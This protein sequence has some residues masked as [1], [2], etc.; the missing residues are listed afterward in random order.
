[1]NITQIGIDLA[2]AVFQVHGVDAR[3]KAVLRKQLR[4]AQLASFF[5]RL[6]PCLVG[7]E[8]CGG[9]HFWARKLTGLGH[10]V[11]NSHC[12]AG[13]VKPYVKTNKNDV[14]D[15]EAICE[16]VG[17]PNMRFVP[18]KNTDQQTLLALHRA[19]AGF[20]H[21]AYGASQSGPR[22]IGGV[23]PD[24]SD[25]HPLLRAEVAGDSRGCRK[26]P[27]RMRPAHSLLGCSITFVRCIVRCRSSRRQ[28]TIGTRSMR[29]ASVCKRFPASDRS[30]R[31]RWSLASVMP[32]LTLSQWPSV[33]GVARSGSTAKARLA[34]KPELLGISKR[35]DTYLRTRC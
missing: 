30:P 11:K 21:R 6:P 23:W 27:A 5:A 14:A 28:S 2:K 17:R 3:G 13:F 26:R 35:G 16:A 10:T 24:H 32:G 18:V 20:C 31:V 9:A 15:A 29:R 7:M 4:R 1:M 25:R 22:H 12:T 19:R 8:A 34:A 33:C